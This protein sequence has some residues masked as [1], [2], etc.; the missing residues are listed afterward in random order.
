MR[1]IHEKASEAPIGASAAAKSI[2]VYAYGCG[3][4]LRRP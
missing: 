2:M 3:A 4:P 1:A